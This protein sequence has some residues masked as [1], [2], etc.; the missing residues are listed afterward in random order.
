MAAYRIAKI[1]KEFM[2]A[3]DTGCFS[4]TYTRD[5]LFGATDNKWAASAARSLQSNVP[6]LINPDTNNFYI[7]GEARE[8]SAYVINTWFT[9]IRIYCLNYGISWKFLK[10]YC[11]NKNT[12]GQYLY[13]TMLAKTCGLEE[14]QAASFQASSWIEELLITGQEDKESY[15]QFKQKVIMKYSHEIEKRSALMFKQ[16]IYEDCKKLAALST[17]ALR[18]KDRGEIWL[19]SEKATFEK[20][21]R[22]SILDAALMYNEDVLSELKALYTAKPAGVTYRS[23]T[24]DERIDAMAGNF[25]KELTNRNRNERLDNEVSAV[26]SSSNNNKH[27][28][29]NKTKTEQRNSSTS[30]ERKK[31]I[32]NCDLCESLGISC[33]MEN[34]HCRHVGHQDTRYANKIKWPDSIYNFRRNCTNCNKEENPAKTYN[35]DKVNPNKTS[36]KN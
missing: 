16:N 12:I 9:E 33:K 23:L 25:E 21:E 31:K 2:E 20:R 26:A 30:R 15:A 18:L 3:R 32:R 8:L 28:K 27:T 17:H 35:K 24:T 19:E 22:E 5:H 13:N 11:L 7:A 14:L 10:D 1:G 36:S 6:K 4:I 34:G 29:Q